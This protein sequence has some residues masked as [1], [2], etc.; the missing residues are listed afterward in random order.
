MRY[1][2]N[3]IILIGA[4]GFFWVCFIYQNDSIPHYND[5]KTD[6]GYTGAIVPFFQ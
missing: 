1:I 2:E 5:N 3:I 6:W 4:I